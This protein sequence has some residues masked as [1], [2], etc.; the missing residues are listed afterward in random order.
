MTLYACLA[1]WGVPV[2]RAWVATVV[3][4]CVLPLGRRKSLPTVFLWVAATVL[5][6]DPLA[7]LQAGFWLSFGAVA[8]LLAQFSS[9]HRTAVAD[10][11][12]DYGATRAWPCD[13]ARAGVDDR[14]CCVGWSDRKPHRRADC[15][16]RCCSTRSRRRIA[17]DAIRYRRDLAVARDGLDRR[18][19]RC[20]PAGA[21]SLRVDRFCGRAQ[22]RR[23]RDERVG[24]CA[25]ALAVAVPTSRVAV[26]LCIAAVRSRH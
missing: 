22:H 17:A 26:A 21:R 10:A 19:R 7:P 9:R 24:V 3:V 8:I 11:H 16:R 25:D 13:G 20:V 5:T 1:G 18:R 12:A 4:L 23:D 15:Q 14:Q 6:C 2:L